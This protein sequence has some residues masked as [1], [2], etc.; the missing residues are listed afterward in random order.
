MSIFGDLIRD[1]NK[2]YS[3]RMFRLWLRLLV[4]K[5]VAIVAVPQRNGYL[6]GP[7]TWVDTEGDQIHLSVSRVQCEL[8][9]HG[10]K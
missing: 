4:T 10:F 7:K 2:I 8:K 1:S 5:T 6:K 3:S 9:V